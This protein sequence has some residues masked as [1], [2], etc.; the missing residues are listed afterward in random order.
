MKKNVLVE[1][2]F[3]KD[4]AKKVSDVVAEIGKLEGST[5]SVVSFRRYNVGESV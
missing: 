5:I 1:Q 2:T 3:I 4:S